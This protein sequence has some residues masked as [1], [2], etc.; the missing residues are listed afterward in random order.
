MIGLAV[1]GRPKPWRET[2]ASER[3]RQFGSVSD[4]LEART[5]N[6]TRSCHRVIGEHD[7]GVMGERDGR[8]F[9]ENIISAN[10]PGT[11]AENTASPQ[12]NIK[13]TYG[14]FGLP[15]LMQF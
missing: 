8:A 1:L 7:W 10:K 14:R 13:F 3:E 12:H 4:T 6:C 5:T 2:N 9:G 11:V 15:R